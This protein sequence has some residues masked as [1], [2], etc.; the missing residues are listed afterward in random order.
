MTRYVADRRPSTE[1]PRAAAYNGESPTDAWCL[2]PPPAT[3]SPA[4]VI[5]A[6]AVVAPILGVVAADSDLLP[7]RFSGD[8]RTDADDWCQDFEDYVALRRISTA[9]AALL[10]RTRM[11]GAA[12]TWL[13]GVPAGTAINE[14]LAKFR[15]RFGAGDACRP[16]FMAEFWERRQEP[17]EPAGRYL[18]EKARLAPVSYTHLTLPTIYSV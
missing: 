17:D 2:A 13:E 12:R 6:P 8:R 3:T 7:P 14:V 9:D 1:A 15:Q 10:F 4:A 11:T 18:E 16:E 5:S